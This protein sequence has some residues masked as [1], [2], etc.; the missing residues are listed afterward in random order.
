MRFR[1]EAVQVAEKPDY[2]PL[3]RHMMTRAFEFYEDPENE[4][5]FQEWM[6]AGGPEKM[7]AEWRKQAEE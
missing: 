6:A 2:M 4:K 1:I 3:A 5:R 7:R